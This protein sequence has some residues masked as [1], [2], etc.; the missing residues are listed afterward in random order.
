[1]LTCKIMVRIEGMSEAGVMP[2][3]YIHSLLYPYL[4]TYLR[5]RRGPELPVILSAPLRRISG[6]AIR[7][8]SVDTHY[9][10]YFLNVERLG[11]HG[12]RAGL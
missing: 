10:D 4:N 12:L 9:L 7:S 8:F 11:E 2:R 6:Y 1:M 3:P 5:T